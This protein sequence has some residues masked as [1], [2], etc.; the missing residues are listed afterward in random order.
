MIPWELPSQLSELVDNEISTSLSREENSCLME[1]I[2]EEELDK[3]E[4][5]FSFSHNNETE[6]I[7]AKKARMLSR[8]CSIHEYDEFRTQ[9]DTV[10]EFSDNSDTPFLCSRRN[11]RGKQD[12][13][14]SSD[15]EDEKIGDGCNIFMN[16][17]GNNEL[18]FEGSLPFTEVPFS[19]SDDMD[20]KLQN[21]SE[22]VGCIPINDECKSL[23]VSCVPESTFVPETEIYNGAEVHLRD[24]MEEVSVSNRVPVE[25]DYL[26]ISK[27]EIQK[28]SDTFQSNQ[29]V[30][31]F[32]ELEEMDDSQNEHV[33]AVAIENQVMDESSRMDFHRLPKYVEKPKPLV[34]TDLVQK[35]WNKLR[36]CRADL[37]QYV[38]S[39]EQQHLQIVKLTDEVSNL[40]SE[41]DV[42]LSNCQPLTGVSVM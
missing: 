16:R 27:S 19:A 6:T 5:E 42:L 24:T 36:V 32:C 2:E 13:I 39:E 4:I 25:A 14:L 22:A 38:R 35:L 33:E 10:H 26:D 11:A 23:D 31:E 20:E 7:E 41:T 40:I 8:N 34:V 12:M 18:F 17:D 30:A 29:C 21:C 1:A 28:D 3:R 15:S 9:L 37:A